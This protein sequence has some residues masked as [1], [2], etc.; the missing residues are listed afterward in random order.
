MKG[1]KVVPRDCG[2]C[3]GPRLTKPEGHDLVA[4]RVVAEGTK[5]GKPK[6]LG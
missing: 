3:M 1:V 5:N 6:K 2:G 4:L